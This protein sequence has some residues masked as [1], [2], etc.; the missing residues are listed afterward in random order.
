MTPGDPFDPVE[1]TER[2]FTVIK[3]LNEFDKAE[4][5][6]VI[7]TLVAPRER[8]IWPD[9]GAGPYAGFAGVGQIHCATPP[10]WS[11]VPAGKSRGPFHHR[12]GVKW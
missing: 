10:G 8:D 9:R 1:I 7:Q 4:V 3:S 5:R 6:G 12:R 11:A 2:F